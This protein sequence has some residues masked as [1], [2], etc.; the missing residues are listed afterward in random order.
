MSKSVLKRGQGY[1]VV[2]PWKK[3]ADGVAAAEWFGVY[4]DLS[5]AKDSAE[6]LAKNDTK[7]TYM[8]VKIEWIS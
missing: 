4:T 1:G 3:D 6:D 8:V 5:E 7:T 2:A